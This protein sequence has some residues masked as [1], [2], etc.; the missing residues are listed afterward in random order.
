M[1][2]QYLQ[3]TDIEYTTLTN[4]RIKIIWS[5]QEM[6]KKL[7]TKFNTHKNSPESGHRGNISQHNKGHIWRTHSKHHP[8]WWKTES[9]SSKIRNKTRMS[10]LTTNI[11]HTFGSPSHGN[12]KRKR[13]KRNTN[14][15]RR[16]ETVTACRWHDTIHRES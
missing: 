11:Q 9:I 16:S 6:Q 10:T 7:L 1:V 12:Q 15:K 3:I 8:Q 2:F 5:S 14:W 13:N 4:W